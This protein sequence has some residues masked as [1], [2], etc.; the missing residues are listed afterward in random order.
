MTYLFQSYFSP[1]ASWC[2]WYHGLIS[3]SCQW[4]DVNWKIIKI[5]MIW[6]NKPISDY[7]MDSTLPWGGAV[8]VYSEEI[9]DGMIGSAVCSSTSAGAS[10]GWGASCAWGE[11]GA[12]CVWTSGEEGDDS[13][14]IGDTAGG[15]EG[16]AVFW[17]FACDLVLLGPFL[18]TWLDWGHRHLSW[19]FRSLPICQFADTTTK[20]L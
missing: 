3:W 2:R 17:R 6:K 13:T 14:W 18:L 12:C 4:N 16:G 19:Y 1:L 5:I 9:T 8:L 11:D 20:V 10:R 7:F 15:E